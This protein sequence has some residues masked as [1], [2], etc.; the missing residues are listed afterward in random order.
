MNS[1]IEFFLH[2]YDD[3]PSA[4]ARELFRLRRKT[5]RDRLDW[6]V[7]CVED[8]EKDQFDNP[9][10]TYLLGMYEG[11]LLCGARF[12]NATHPTMISE[13]FHNYF[14]NPIIFPADVPCCE[15]SRGMYAIF[16]HANWKVEVIQRG[17]SEKGEVIYYIFMPA[18][19]SIIE[20]IISKD[21]SSHWLR[22]MLEHLRHL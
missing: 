6:K 13:I 17:V 18:S 21:K 10:T 14:D 3:L 9:N 7:E 12:I 20:D 15:V 11:E 5:F 19:I 22:E 16:R 1:V 8:M 4:L 2:D